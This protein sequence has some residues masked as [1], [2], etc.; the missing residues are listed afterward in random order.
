[1]DWKIIISELL[2][3]G[4]TQAQIAAAAGVKQ[5]TI[6]GLLAGTQKDM[7][8]SS[9]E[10]LRQL[11]KNTCLAQRVPAMSEPIATK[12]AAGGEHA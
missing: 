1:M 4:L 8:W 11:H 3:S 2:S 10:K 5:P 7:R 9:G 12:R 6:A